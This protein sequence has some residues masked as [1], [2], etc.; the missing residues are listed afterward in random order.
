MDEEE[1]QE[2]TTKKKIF[3]P[4]QAATLSEL[5]TSTILPGV[6][7]TEQMY[8]LALIDTYKQMQETQGALDE[9]GVRFLL[10][11]KMF[12]FMRRSL[13]GKYQP[14]SLLPSDYIWALHSESQETI[15]QAC[16]PADADWPTAKSLGVGLWLTNPTTLRALV[17]KI[18]KVNFM[19]KK[20]PADSALF[21]LA[22]KKKGA[23]IVL[24]KSA[25]EQKL[26]DFLSRDFT[27]Q[28]NITAAAKNAYELS[29]L[30]RQ[31]LRFV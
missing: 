16:L 9:R 25:K 24:Y 12:S 8:L 18:A 26:V 21:Y 13:Q 27:Q 20:D 17:E 10:A 4:K 3:G 14:V 5:L 6:S 7:G 11:T 15:V 22:L 19:A 31:G 30:H 2:Q 23:L 28:K 1:Q 29:K